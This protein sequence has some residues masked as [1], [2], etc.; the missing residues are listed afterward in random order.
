LASAAAIIENVDVELAPADVAPML[1]DALHVC[2][3]MFIHHEV[4]SMQSKINIQIL[5]IYVREKTT[6]NKL[7][8]QTYVLEGHGMDLAGVR[9]R[10]RRIIGSTGGTGR[11]SSSVFDAEGTG[12]KDSIHGP[13]CHGPTGGPNPSLCKGG[14]DVAQHSRRRCRRP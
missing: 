4:R 13:V 10:R 6:Q 8:K 14:C 9:W 3:C 12:A 2:I 5:C 1:V 7:E 11:S